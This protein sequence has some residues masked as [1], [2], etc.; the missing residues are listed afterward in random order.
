MYVC[1]K[2]SDPSI[3]TGIVLNRHVKM[4]IKAAHECIT[5]IVEMVKSI[6]PCNKHPIENT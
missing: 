6:E 4:E 1:I 2:N 3:P 5:K